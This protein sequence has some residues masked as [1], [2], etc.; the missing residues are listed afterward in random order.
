MLLLLCSLLGLGGF[1]VAVVFLLGWVGS[2]TYVL[3]LGLPRWFA[4]GF[5]VFIYCFV[6]C[7]FDEL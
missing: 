2:I 3:V 6:G 5:A 4:S 1:A 7:L